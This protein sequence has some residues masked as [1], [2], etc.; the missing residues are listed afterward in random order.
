MSSFPTRMRPYFVT[1]AAV[2]GVSLI[3]YALALALNLES[4]LTLYYTTVI[5]SAWYG[6]RRQ[7]FLATALVLFCGWWFFVYPNPIW[8]DVHHYGSRFI[9]FGVDCIIV[10]LISDALRSA[11]AKSDLAL[12]AFRSAQTISRESQMRFN[13]VYESN[14]IGLMTAKTDGTIIDCNDYVLDLLGYD[15]DDLRAGR[16]NWRHMTPPEFRATGDGT[17]ILL[18]NNESVK[19]YEKEYMRKD[20]TRTPVMVG[21]ARLADGVAVVFVLDIRE[22][23][24]NEQFL[25]RK[26]SER[27]AE[28]QAAA[29]RLQQSE[30]FLDSVIENL[31]AMVFVK[32]ADDLRFVRFNRA[33]ERL[34][35]HSREELIGKSDYDLFPKEQADFFV[36]KDRAVLGGQEVVEIAEEPLSTKNGLR[37]LHT[38]KIPILGGDGKPVYLLGIAEDI[39][40]R[41]AAEQQRISLLQEQAAREQA[42]KSADQLRILTEVGA[43]LNE[44]LNLKSR[45]ESFAQIVT[46]NFGDWCEI[47]LADVAEEKLQ[48][49]VIYHRD[50]AKRE[51]ANQFRVAHE[52][53]WESPVGPAHVLRT[54]KPEFH[55]VMADSYS[56]ASL[57]AYVREA[58]SRLQVHSSIIVPLQIYGRTI[59]S[60]SIG[61]AE[62]KRRFT[63][64]DLSLAMDFAKR[65]AFAIE[66]SRLFNQAQEA[67]QAKSAFLA[68][69]SHEIRTP[70]GAMLGFAELLGDDRLSERQH[71]YL[72]TLLRNGQQLLRIV[73]EILDLAK[74]E[75]ELIQ[76]ENL[77]FSP[78]DLIGEVVSLL[79]LQA[80]TKGISL[81]VAALEQLPARVMSDPTRLR[82]ILLNVIGNA[83]KFTARGS[84]EIEVS[85]HERSTQPNRAVLEI[86]VQDSGIGIGPGQGE[87]LFQAF[88]QADNSTTR[89]F[90]G[91]GLGL[92]LS[93]RLARLMGGDVVLADS[94]P[95]Q[96]SK[97]VVTVT[98]EVKESLARLQN[99][100]EA[101]PVTEP[102][103]KSK[104]LVVDDAPDNRM[105]I[106]LLISR[107][108][109]SAD[110]A[111]G[112]QEAVAKALAC[113]YDLILMDVQM[114]EMDGFEA[115]SRLRAKNYSGP[116]VALTAHTMKG[117]R[118]RCLAG[119]F[120]GY[121][122]KPIDRTQL[123]DTLV[124]Y[125]QR[126]PST[127]ASSDSLTQ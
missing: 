20:G 79:Q 91:T 97:F 117:D 76:I 70:L 8:E 104:I 29:E 126:T 19:P 75:S 37:Y 83:V 9:L 32:D 58:Y 101:A 123:K 115:V 46:S 121:L 77:E 120:D 80:V 43:A 55:P 98:V 102:A 28:L 124:K 25:E 16:I 71:E 36:A 60:L 103:H 2:V 68:N 86:A 127:G 45:L 107:L 100:T 44:S 41:K 61:N 89:K 5:L 96:G 84:V 35:G 95:V 59:G 21:A 56:T 48:E 30:R 72:N 27:T 74:V 108:G 11:R 7:G 31:P 69:M 13:R 42:E 114:P 85:M 105:L 57:P 125:V 110:V 38:R 51:F 67:S 119:G 34:L 112:G 54:G 6:G 81:N 122:G 14:M 87:R 26:V 47:V 40:E 24:R 78:G 33:G 94:Q 4:P 15:S 109:Y 23:K 39:T 116:I 65:A 53:A 88:M 111:A 73:D 64:L 93:R 66:N 106:E 63:E 99:G 113:A 82:Q 49:S 92:F 10:T 90:G 12:A 50:P 118:E 22:R 62:T 3:K 52:I 18:K 1:I 17:S